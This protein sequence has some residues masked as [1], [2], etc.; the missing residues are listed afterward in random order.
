MYVQ[1]R[2][3]LPKPEYIECDRHAPVYA[4]GT[5]DR[6]ACEHAERSNN[7]CLS[8]LYEE[9]KEP[10]P[11]LVYLCM[12]GLVRCIR[13]FSTGEEDRAASGRAAGGPAFRE[14][15]LPAGGKA[16]VRVR[17]RAGPEGDVG[18]REDGPVRYLQGGRTGWCTR[19]WLYARYIAEC[20]VC[21]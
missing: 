17:E 16:V 6:P 8:G 1:A 11:T 13:P 15:R 5:S 19:R 4:T 21:F 7:S 20:C 9:G 3:L 14:V 18:G 12:I 10:T 2:N